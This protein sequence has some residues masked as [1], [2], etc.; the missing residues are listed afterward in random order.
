MRTVLKANATHSRQNE[1]RQR[2][3]LGCSR[4]ISEV[5]AYGCLRWEVIPAVA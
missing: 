2:T 3:E 5:T 4:L 1:A